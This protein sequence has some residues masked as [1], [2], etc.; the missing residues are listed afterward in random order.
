VDVRV[1]A[2][3]AKDLLSEV[4]R[5]CFRED[6]YYRLNVLPIHLPPLR[7]R[8]EDIP[9]LVEH[10]I[11][12]YNQSHSLTCG[13]TTPAA[14]KLLVSYPWPG[15]IRELENIIERA[16]ILSGR[17]RI[18]SEALPQAVINYEQQTG[19]L[20]PEDILSIKI[21]SVI[22]EKQLISRALKKT[23]GNKSQAAKLLELSYPALLSKISEYGIEP[24]E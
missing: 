12:K 2:A 1:I 16:M 20:F 11:K 5:G 6:L 10:F 18:D 15:N 3:T 8:L 7:D 17:D 14:L 19:A 4:Q 24:E 22:M 23:R 21:M 13:G 9:L